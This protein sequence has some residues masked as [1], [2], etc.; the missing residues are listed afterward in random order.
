V[1]FFRTLFGFGMGAEWTSGAT[2]AM[3][4]WPARSRGIASGILQ[5]SW[6]I[7]YIL[8]ALASSVVVPAYG[9]RA[10][11]LVAALPALL[12][13]PIRIWV[14]E[15]PDWKK[16][17][18]AQPKISS[19]ELVREGVLGR[20]AWASVLW[21]TCF[22]IYYGLTGLWPTLLQTE[23]GVARGELSTLVILFNL[24]MMGGAIAC[25]AA[26]SRY[27]VLWALAAP[28]AA[29]LPI[30]P[31]YVG[32]APPYL[33][34]GALLA[35]AFGAGISGV[36][37]MLLTLLF[38]PAV[39]ARSVGIVYHVGALVAAI[40]PT[41][42]ATLAAGGRMPL[43]RALGGTVAGAAVITLAVLFI[44]PKNMLPPEALAPRAA[45]SS[46]GSTPASPQSHE[47]STS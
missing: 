43:S 16:A 14:P 30:I 20:I 31:L 19:R 18:A 23:L 12:V 21:G 8:A 27:G 2:L 6:A 34:L 33:W 32:A 17:R 35:G 28:I 4:N 24:G 22:A 11:F 45:S 1:L 13:L 29:L 5:G 10:L 15:S 46:P 41:L 3:E 26:A 47:R 44:R 39:R 25:G 42:V 36:T 38:P 9:W 40:T 7:G 37:P